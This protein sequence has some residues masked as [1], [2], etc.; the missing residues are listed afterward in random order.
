M[1]AL[2]FVRFLVLDVRVAPTAATAKFYADLSS[3]L[4]EMTQLKHL[5]LQVSFLDPP[6]FCPAKAVVALTSLTCLMVDGH[7]WTR[8]P[9]DLDVLTHVPLLRCLV[10]D[11]LAGT[12]LHDLHPLLRMPLTSLILDYEGPRDTGF[13][14]CV[15]QESECIRASFGWPRLDLDFDP[16][17]FRM[18]HQ[19]PAWAGL[20]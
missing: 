12:Q 3:V 16:D 6:S 19:L 4:G 7:N 17:D 15:R 1:Q 18:M 20:E 11:V 2:T 10:I 13:E 5:D 14:K 9:G 8:V